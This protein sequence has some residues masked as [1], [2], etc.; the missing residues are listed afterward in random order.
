MTVYL[1][2]AAHWRKDAWWNL[3]VQAYESEPEA[4]RRLVGMPDDEWVW[5]P[6]LQFRIVRVTCDV[7]ILPKHEVLGPVVNEE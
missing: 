1:L 2:Q 4:R 6:G 7:E 5:T 3:P